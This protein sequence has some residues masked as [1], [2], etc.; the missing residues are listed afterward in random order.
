M[1]AEKLALLIISGHTYLWN[2]NPRNKVYVSV[3]E[4]FHAEFIPKLL[5]YDPKT[6][7]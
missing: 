6:K 7:E 5:L 1:P 4:M 2:M 3:W